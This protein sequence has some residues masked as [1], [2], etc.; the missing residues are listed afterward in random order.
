MRIAGLTLLAFGLVLVSR[1]LSGEEAQKK[2]KLDGTWK[3]VSVIKNGKEEPD[4]KD[5]SLIIEGDKFTI[6]EGDKLHA[7]GTVKRDKSKKPHTIDFT[8]TKADDAKVE[9]KTLKGIYELKGDT[10]KWCFSMPDEERPTEFAAPAGSKALF[11]TLKRA[12]E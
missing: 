3:P 4:K 2:S 10:L 6:R 7:S 12:K 5:H 11:I 9:G 8:V 1:G